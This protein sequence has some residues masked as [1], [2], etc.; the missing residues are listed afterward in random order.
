MICAQLAKLALVG[1]EELVD[2]IVAQPFERTPDSLDLA[3]I[4]PNPED[5]FGLPQGTKR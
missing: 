5:H 2:P 3:K 4:N 1:S